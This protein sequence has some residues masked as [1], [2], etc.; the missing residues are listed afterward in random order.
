MKFRK[1]LPCDLAH[2]S[3]IYEAIHDQEECG[4][5]VVGWTRGVYPTPETARQALVR[6]DLFV[7]E[8]DGKIVGSAI[9]NQQQVDVYADGM[10]K[11]DAPA[12]EVMV[13]H[14]LVISPDVS[15]RG[16]GSSFVRYYEQYARSH[17]CPYL[18]MDTNAK[19]AA[20]RSLYRK[21]GYDEIG[22]VPCVF[23]G[24]KGVQLVLLEKK[25]TL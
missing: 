24:I 6:N 19:N 20:A 7:M 1:A 10:W 17:G 16:F 15:G 23:N 25:L 18:R 2:I 11:H 22:V 5:S 14:T 12:S 21:L 9:I 3:G 4:K 8:S 13:L